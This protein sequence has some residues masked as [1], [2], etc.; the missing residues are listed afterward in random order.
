[1]CIIF[2]LGKTHEESGN[3]WK[4]CYSLWC[5]TKKDSKENWN[6]AASKVYLP[7]LRKGLMF[8][9]RNFL[10]IFLWYFKKNIFYLN[11]CFIIGHDEEAGGRDLALLCLSKN[12]R[13][14]RLGV[15]VSS[16]RLYSVQWVLILPIS[17][18]FIILLNIWWLFIYIPLYPQIELLSR[19]T[20]TAA[21]VRSAI[22]RLRE[23]KEWARDRVRHSCSDS[24]FPPLF[25]SLIMLSFPRRFTLSERIFEWINTL[26]S[27]ASFEIQYSVLA[28]T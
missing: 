13:W 9:C 21:S 6:F 11:K 3:C 26:C 19:S 5:F 10:R 27:N 28:L 25:V 17:Y 23:L 2:V 20:V 1:M 4:V 15:Q 12:S 8:Y 18:Q 16:L 24:L 22:R 14:R 7:V